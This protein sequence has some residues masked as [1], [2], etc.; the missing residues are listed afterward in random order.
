MLPAIEWLIHGSIDWFWEIP[1]LSGPALGFLAVAVRSV[2]RTTSTDADDVSADELPDGARAA[3]TPAGA[4][5]R[6]L[7]GR[8]CLLAAG[9]GDRARLPYLSVRE[10]STASDIAD[11]RP[12]GARSHDLSIAAD[13]NPLDSDP[14]RFAGR[15][16]PA[17]RADIRSPSSASTVDRPRARRLVLA[18]WERASPR[19]ARATASVPG[20]TSRVAHSTLLASRRRSTWHCTASNGRPA[21]DVRRGV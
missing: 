11:Q 20:T 13:L 16:R 17:L 14:D 8:G 4:R 5:A 9:G 12:P 21:A 10:V 1:A 18:G 15:D 6:A 19:R 7:V 3:V 2:G